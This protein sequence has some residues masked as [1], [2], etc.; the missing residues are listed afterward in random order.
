[1]RKELLAE[2]SI[3]Y[4]SFI[5]RQGCLF[6]DIILK[7]IDDQIFTIAYC[8]YVVIVVFFTISFRKHNTS[9]EDQNM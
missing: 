1:V 2:I 9:D 7:A 6:G 3:A 4:K 5:F 8:K